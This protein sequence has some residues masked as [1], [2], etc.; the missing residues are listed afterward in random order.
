[1]LLLSPEKVFLGVAFEARE[2]LFR[3]RLYINMNEMK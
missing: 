1:M 3:G 2:N